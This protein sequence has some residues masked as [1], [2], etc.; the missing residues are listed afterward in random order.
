L[1]EHQLRIRSVDVPGIDEEFYIKEMSAQ[2]AWSVEF[3]AKKGEQPE[4]ALA[5]I[6]SRCNADGHLVYPCR[7]L[8]NGM[9]YD[10]EIADKIREMPSGPM[11][12]IT[13]AIRALQWLE[14]DAPNRSERTE[15]VAAKNE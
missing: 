1:F 2:A 3:E 5:I 6:A 15:R 12:V 4:F 14:P 9:E 10:K 7:F 13:A 8:V 11:G